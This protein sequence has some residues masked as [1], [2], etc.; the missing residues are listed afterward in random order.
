M[1]IEAQLLA[2]LASVPMFVERYSPS[3][4]RGSVGEVISASL[5]AN[6]DMQRWIS[7]ERGWRE[8]LTP[9]EHDVMHEVMGA[10]LAELGYLDPSPVGLA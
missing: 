8:N 9:D 4:D 5:R 2:Q 6:N 10:K 3:S 7:G 1:L